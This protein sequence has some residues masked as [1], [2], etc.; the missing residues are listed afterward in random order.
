MRYLQAWA[1]KA[2]QGKRPPGRGERGPLLEC[3]EHLA[4]NSLARL[5]GSADD[6]GA[7]TGGV[8]TV[9][10]VFIVAL[11]KAGEGLQ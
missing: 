3:S 9:C 1:A 6:D 10:A 7:A 2:R 11:C 8:A 5:G 4:N